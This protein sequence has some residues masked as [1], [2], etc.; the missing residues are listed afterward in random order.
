MSFLSTKDAPRIA[1]AARILGR[2]IPDE[3]LGALGRYA[4]LVATWNARMNLT[5]A[6]DARALCDVLF[7]DAFV[8]ADEAIVAPDACIVDVG[9]GAGAPT[10]PL[11]LVRPDV[12]ATL[13]EPARKRV[14]FLRTAVGT[15]QLEARSRIEEVRLENGAVPGAPFDLALSRAT[16]EPAEWLARG[17]ELAPKIVVLGTAEPLPSH[18]RATLVET[19]SYRLPFAGTERTLGLFA[20]K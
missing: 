4:E 11:L 10:L 5:G 3:V 13:I 18:D 20:R 9:A 17:L 1:E 15:L 19:R 8:L 2:S 12:K 16:F 6:R 14:A 7:A